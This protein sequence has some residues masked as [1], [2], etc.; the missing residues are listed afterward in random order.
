MSSQLR[1]E[2]NPLGLKWWNVYVKA[3]KKGKDNEPDKAVTFFCQY[4][5]LT[6]REAE[7]RAITFVNTT[8]TSVSRIKSEPALPEEIG[9]PVPQRVRDPFADDAISATTPL[10]LPAPPPVAAS[11]EA[12]PEERDEDD[13]E[14]KRIKRAFGY[15]PLTIEPTLYVQGEAK[16]S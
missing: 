10:A 13:E 12:K 16:A 4:L 8:G 7:L 15:V 6:A 2:S 11:P 14:A 9:G 3:I 5:C 1:A